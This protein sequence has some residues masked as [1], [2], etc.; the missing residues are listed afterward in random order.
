MEGIYPE[1][2]RLDF[3]QPVDVDHD[4]LG[5]QLCYVDLVIEAPNA[6]ER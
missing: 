3:Q 2:L 6:L 1:S 5:T 4:L